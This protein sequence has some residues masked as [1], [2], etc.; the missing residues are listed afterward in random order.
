M[1]GEWDGSDPLSATPMT[2]S[3]SQPMRW[4]N[5]NRVMT[6]VFIYSGSMKTITTVSQS[7]PMTLRAFG[8]LPTEDGT[9]TDELD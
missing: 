6:P 5:G 3:P 8:E 7:N 1:D 9:E 2:G 4:K